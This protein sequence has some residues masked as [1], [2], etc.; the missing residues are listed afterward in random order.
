[1]LIKIPMR[2]IRRLTQILLTLIGSA[3]ILYAVLRI[4]STYSRVLVVA[5]GLIF[6]EA[7]IWELTR[8]LFPNER[9][10]RPLRKE[11]DY[12][13]TIVRRLNRA[14]IRA[15]AN[16]VGS[17]EEVDRLHTEMHHSV[18][19]MRRLAGLSDDELGFRYKGG[20]DVP[21]SF[22]PTAGPAPAITEDPGK[23]SARA[24]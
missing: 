7:G 9:E 24:S 15:R 17:S 13:L 21:A 1:M 18:D 2:R 16:A 8:S 14:S 4:E 6:V 11:T 3:V 10:F 22:D 5:I 19:R 20:A 12:F 23:M